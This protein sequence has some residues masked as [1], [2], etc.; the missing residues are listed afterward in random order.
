MTARILVT[1]PSW[2]ISQVQTSVILPLLPTAITPL[3]SLLS[4][5]SDGPAVVDYIHCLAGELYVPNLWIQAQT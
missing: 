1:K 4:P 3:K 5:S 2:I